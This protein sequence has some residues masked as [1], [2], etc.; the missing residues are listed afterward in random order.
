MFSEERI[1][2]RKDEDWASTFNQGHDNIKANQDKL[3][4][5]KILD[6]AQKEVHGW[7]KQ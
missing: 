1:K 6:M 2:I 4:I 5:R 7:I 3:V